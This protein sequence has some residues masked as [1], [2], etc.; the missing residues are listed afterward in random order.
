M[1]FAIREVGTSSGFF[2]NTNPEDVILAASASNRRILIGNTQSN[3]AALELYSNVANVNG[4]V[5]AT[6]M[7]TNTM[8]S[9]S[10]ALYM[11]TDGGPT[12]QNFTM[13]GTIADAYYASNMLKTLVGSNNIVTCS[14]LRSHSNVGVGID[15]STSNTV[16]PVHIESAYNNVSL[17]SRYDI[18]AMSDERVKENF[19]VIGDAL[20]KV[21]KIS[22]YTFERKDIPIVEGEPRP[23]HCGL[24]AQE[25]EQVLPEAVHQDPSTGMKT[26]TYGNV[27][28]L[29]INAIKELDA[30]VNA[31]N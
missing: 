28:S 2:R 25:L 5:L 29:L 12:H 31:T 3:L 4:N 18:T 17:F 21:R 14:E 10:L 27:V 15:W 23:R 8:N 22:G 11:P 1:A 26:V 19:E 6:H 9:T 13:P 30:K 24:I 16:Y 7:S 20:D